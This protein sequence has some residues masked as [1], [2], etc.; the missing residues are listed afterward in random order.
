MLYA[1][2]YPNL[3]KWVLLLPNS[4]TELSADLFRLHTSMPWN[5]LFQRSK[6]SLQID[7]ELLTNRSRL[8]MTSS[9]NT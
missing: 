7:R 4:P 2:I 3:R 5:V 6:N 1:L 9:E 8:Y